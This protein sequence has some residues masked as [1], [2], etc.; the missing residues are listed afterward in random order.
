MLLKRWQLFCG[1]E[2]EGEDITGSLLAC[3]S[4]SH[5]F[6]ILLEP[7]SKPK[8]SNTDFLSILYTLCVQRLHA[9]D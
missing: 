1:H 8:G 7:Y 2:K 5:A 4:Q 3:P 6:L 9:W